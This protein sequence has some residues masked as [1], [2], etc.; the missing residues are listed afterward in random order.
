MSKRKPDQVD[1]EDIN[2]Y[3]VDKLSKIPSW[4][5]IILLKYWAAAAAVLFGVI[6]IIDFGL[7]FSQMDS[8]NIIAIVNTHEQIIIILA[9]IIAMINN[10]A[11]KQVVLMMNNRRNNTF[12]FNIINSKGLKAFLLYIIY[13]LLMSLILFFVTLFLSSKGWVLPILQ[14]EGAGIEPFTYGLCYIIIDGIFV[15]IKNLC[16]M[17]YQRISYYKQLRRA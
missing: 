1:Y 6:G 2:P 5:V 17:I 15:S 13:S 11:V 10:Y 16:V 9:L 3:Q 8:N 14:N 12:K 4:I 7:D